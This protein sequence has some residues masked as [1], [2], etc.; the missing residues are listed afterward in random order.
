MQFHHYDQGEQLYT[1]NA[2]LFIEGSH[3]STD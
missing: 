1:E 3:L 2:L